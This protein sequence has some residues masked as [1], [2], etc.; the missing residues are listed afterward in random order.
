MLPKPPN[1][2]Q[3][4]QVR[5]ISSKITAKITFD[6][7]NSD[8]L[9]ALRSDDPAAQAMIPR[10]Q[11]QFMTIFTSQLSSFFGI[12]GSIVDINK[13]GVKKA[14]PASVPPKTAQV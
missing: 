8:I 5:S 7:S 4:A 12:K 13:D 2:Q 10:I 6:H 1:P 9:I 3:Q 11:D 14:A